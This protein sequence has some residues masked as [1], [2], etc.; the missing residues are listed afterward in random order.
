MDIIVKGIHFKQHIAHF[1]L[2]PFTW[3]CFTLIV[4]QVKYD[5]WREAAPRI[6]SQSTNFLN[7]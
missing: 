6:V 4:L 7:I 2:V 1:C 5:F 3:K